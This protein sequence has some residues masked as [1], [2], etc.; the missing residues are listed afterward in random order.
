MGAEPPRSIWQE[1]ETWGSKLQR[2][3]RFVLARAVTES[4]LVDDDV[5]VA[6]RLMLADNGLGDEPSP[7]VQVASTITGRPQGITTQLRI[8]AIRKACN[9][10]A[11]P[12]DSELAFGPGLT[13]VYGRNGTGKSGY[14]R[15]LSVSCF[16]RSPSRIVLPNV[17]SPKVPQPAPTA[18][19]VVADG[20][21]PERA[22]AFSQTPIDTELRRIAVFDAA[23]AHVH[24]VGENAFSFQP[25][26]FDVFSEMVRIHELFIKRIETDVT[27]R[28]KPN[29]FSKLFAGS[30]ATPVSNAIAA[31][32]ATTEPTVIRSLGAFGVTEKAL[33]ADTARQL[34]ELRAT[35]VDHLRKQAEQ[36]RADVEG[37]RSSLATA[38]ESFTT[39]RC[40]RY[41]TQLAELQELTKVAAAANLDALKNPGLVVIGSKTW[42]RFVA[43]AF[44]LAKEQ[45]LEYPRRG[46]LCLLCHRPVDDSAHEVLHATW[47]YLQGEARRKSETALSAMRSAASSLRATALDVFQPESRVRAYLD[48]VNP[49]VATAVIGAIQALAD[50]REAFVAT[51]EAGTGP[52][53]EA[54][55]VRATLEQLQAI[56]S[57][58]D[59]DIERLKL[60]NKEEVMRSLT[61]R[62][63]ELRHQEVLANNLPAVVQ[64]LSDLAW[65][66][67]AANVRQ[68]VLRTK[69]ITDKETELS[70]DL[71]G[72]LY[73]TDLASALR[74]LDCDFTLTPKMTGKSGRTVRTLTLSARNRPAEVLSEGE[75][76]AIALADFLTEVNLNPDSAG[77]ILDDPVT[78]LDNERKETIAKRLVKES[79]VRQV[80]VFT[81]DLE[82]LV[83]LCDG[84]ERT[85][86]TPLTHWVDRDG[87]G[88]PGAVSAND[89]PMTSKIYKNAEYARS[90]AKEAKNAVGTARI[91]PLRRGFGAIRTCLEHLV[92]ASM[93]KDLVSPYRRHVK[94]TLLEE[95]TWRPDVAC[96]VSR[97]YQDVS[98]YIDAH[99]RPDGA[100]GSEPTIPQL[101]AFI[102]AY[103]ALRSRAKSAGKS[104]Q[105]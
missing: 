38:Q 96:D 78:S 6:Y 56:V 80:I 41:S 82:F 42:D 83:Q 93:L 22:I 34:A 33:F 97:L 91:Q 19:I 35:S 95:I 36:D 77:I 7:A 49:D 40:E 85:A 27:A 54:V 76:R 65:A 11:L 5:D 47:R 25:M 62:Y 88:N 69:A 8:V 51:L 103:E 75:Q 26:G 99:F 48:R 32:A 20:A 10:N 31:L 90:Q 4:H 63:T 13:V 15:L 24:V 16:S 44:D 67:K 68:R 23:I 94:M 17:Y 57:G 18:D 60:Q 29:D 14:F 89:G 9:V 61:Q 66:A 92:L 43:A 55:S 21:G 59:A 39:E 45:E 50:H 84:C 12:E 105:T 71:I 37:L 64:Y 1:L 28:K 46:A 72:A 53:F 2:W 101:E 58:L 104:A 100:T 73:Q 30:A 3:Q 102:E 52:P 79:T 74:D 87:A 98:A 70:S 81:H 86:I